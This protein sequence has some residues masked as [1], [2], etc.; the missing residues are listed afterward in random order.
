MSE[1]KVPN[2]EEFTYQQPVIDKDLTSPPGG[3]SKGDRYLVYGTGSGA[4]SGQDGNIATY[5]GSGYDF[6]AKSEGMIVYVKD[7]DK[8]YKYITTWTE[9][10]IDNNANNILANQIFG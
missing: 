4:W 6:S 3:E 8:F 7:E 9:F 5:N 2:L 1:Y 10:I